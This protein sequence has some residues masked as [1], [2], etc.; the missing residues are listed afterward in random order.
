MNHDPTRSTA[1]PTAE[2]IF[3]QP[4]RAPQPA[5]GTPPEEDFDA[6]TDLFLGGGV[7]GAQPDEPD[8][9][10]DSMLRITAERDAPAP[11][12][13]PP[14]PIQSAA[15]PTSPPAP[16]PALHITALILGHLPVFASAWANQYARHLAQTTGGPVAVLRIRAGYASV[17]LVATQQL[18]VA[19]SDSLEQAI[20]EAGRFTSRW[21]LRVGELDEPALAGSDRID[22][23]TLLTGVDEAAVVASYQTLKRLRLPPDGGPEITLA[24]MAAD[25]QRARP[26]ARKIT[27]ATQTFLDR[28]TRVVCCIERIAGGPSAHLFGGESPIAFSDALQLIQDANDGAP[29]RTPEATAPAPPVELASSEPTHT[30]RAVPHAF[31]IEPGPVVPSIPGLR[32]IRARCPYADTVSL[33]IDEQGL[34]HLIAR[35]DAGVETQL[36]ELTTARAWLVDHMPL[37]ALTDPRLASEPHAPTTHLITRSPTAVRRLL[38]ADMRIH[39]LVETPARDRMLVP[40]NDPEH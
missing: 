19:Q 38:D 29:H 4:I 6:L 22:E 7:L 23:L 21:V 31:A 14:P 11:Q 5:L 12:P 30:P 33:A 25:A 15:T 32:D 17:D 2:G 10:P 9:G 26:V 1:D 39:L 40:L 16:R 18:N 20:R 37:L 34:V 13:T 36:K 8:P 35:A 24:V 28:Q 3:D 27:Q